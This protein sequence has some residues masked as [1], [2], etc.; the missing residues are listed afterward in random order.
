MDAEL[1]A[2]SELI[3]AIRIGLASWLAA[4]CAQLRHD[5]VYDWIAN[6]LR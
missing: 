3:E 2:G 5:T 6:A 4:V 1:I